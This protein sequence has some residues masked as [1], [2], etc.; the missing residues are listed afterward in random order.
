VLCS[1]EFE[2]YDEEETVRVKAGAAVQCSQHECPA[3]G[4]KGPQLLLIR[5][6]CR[7]LAGCF[8]EGQLAGR[9]RGAGR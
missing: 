5:H 7:P 8:L 1:A 2:G 6:D 3:A 4:C 9:E